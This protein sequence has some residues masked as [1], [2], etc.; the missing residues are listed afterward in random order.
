MSAF[1]IRTNMYG[2][3]G[4]RVWPTRI[5]GLV[6]VFLAVFLAILLGR[7]AHSP[8]HSKA[9]HCAKDTIRLVATHPDFGPECAAAPRARFQLPAAFGER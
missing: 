7:N 5:A 8:A 9:A 1:M 2:R 3:R 6:I 4:P